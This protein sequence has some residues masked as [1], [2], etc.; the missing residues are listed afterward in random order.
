MIATAARQHREAARRNR[1]A[2][3]GRQRHAALAHPGN[4]RQEFGA[5]GPEHDG[6]QFTQ[7]HDITLD[8]S[9]RAGRRRVRGPRPAARHPGIRVHPK[10]LDAVDDKNFSYWH[11]ATFSNDGTKILFT[12]EWGGGGAAEVPS[13]RSARLG[14]RRDLHDRRGPEAALPELL[15]AARRRRRRKRIAS[16]TTVRSFRCRAATSWCRRGIR[17]ASRSSTGPTPTHPK[18]IAFFDRGPIDAIKMVDRRLL[19]GVLV[20]RRHRRARRSRAASTSSSSRRA[21]AHAERDR[22]GE[23]RAPR[24]SERAG[25]AEVL[26]PASFA[27]ARAYVDQLERSNGLSADRLASVRQALSA[28]EAAS[29]T[30]RSTALT[31]VATQLDGDAAKPSDASERFGSFAAA[32]R[33]HGEVARLPLC[34]P[35]SFLSPSLSHSRQVIE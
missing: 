14:R 7:C 11:S 26:W 24:L 13:D 34:L 29:G 9:T 5:E 22:R 17:A 23:D 33:G 3:G 30:A 28:A 21:A 16:R 1:R 25:S 27:L 32:V 31:N 6:I 2:D 20:Q 4:L 8:P 12:D 35:L 18:E 19:V 10:R 15:Q